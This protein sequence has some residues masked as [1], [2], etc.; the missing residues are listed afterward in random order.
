[1]AEPEKSQEEIKEVPATT[2]SAFKLKS[3]F[4]IPIDDQVDIFHK[5]H[6]E[7]EN[8]KKVYTAP[9]LAQEYGKQYGMELTKDDI[10]KLVKRRFL[11]RTY[12]KRE[13]ENKNNEFQLVKE[14]DKTAEIVQTQ[15]RE[16]WSE[17]QDEY[18]D[19]ICGKID[20]LLVAINSTKIAKA[21]ASS[22]VGSIEKLIGTLLD[23]IGQPRRSGTA[24]RGTFS[25]NAQTINLW[26]NRLPEERKK[27]IEGQII[28]RNDRGIEFN[29]EF[30]NPDNQEAGN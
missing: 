3:W 10:H 4:E 25:M 29:N 19:K 20:Q 7:D 28:N 5:F 13:A 30:S 2:V 23:L 16:K 27:I 18:I 14:I 21:N 17:K 26:F 22:L 12:L 15:I 9:Q 1:M 8:R 6:Q 24:E 11:E